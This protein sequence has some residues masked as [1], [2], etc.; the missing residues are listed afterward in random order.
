[1]DSVRRTSIA[2][3]ALLIL[4]T[5]AALAAAELVPALTGA[6]YLTGVADQPQRVAAAAL[7]YL[8]AAVT[9]VGIAIAL[10]PLL[11]KIN[12]AVALAAVVFRTIE[13]VFYTAAVVALLS[14]LPLGQQLATAPADS[15][16]PIR[17]IA[18]AL[19][20]FREHSTLVAVFA[21]SLSALMYYTLFHQA[22]LVPR[23]LTGWGIAGAML[24]LTASL[25]SLFSDNPVTGYILLIL[26][27]AVQEMVLAVWLLVKGFNPSAPSW[28]ASPRASTTLGRNASTV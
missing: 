14:I 1:M 24:M 28:T 19:L 12:A 4:A 7:L 22:R 8:V 6:D 2:I 25:L 15:R 9:S 21:F 10:Y 26:P 23:W 5:I 13:A 16:A 3:G 17:A 20:S 18:D 27:I 11:I